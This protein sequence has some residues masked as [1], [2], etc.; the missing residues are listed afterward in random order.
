[1][2]DDDLLDESQSET[3]ARLLGR[4]ER[5]K[6]LFARVGRNARAIVE[7]RDTSHALRHVESTLHVNVRSD[8]S[9]LARL[10]RVAKQVAEGLSK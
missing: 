2:C 7:D 5:T 4:E 9:A 3:R 6:D 1:M 8:T 10:H